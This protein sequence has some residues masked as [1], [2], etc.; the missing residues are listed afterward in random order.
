[1]CGGGTNDR[2]K[3]NGRTEIV[4]FRSR[5]PHFICDALK[6]AVSFLVLAWRKCRWHCG[7]WIGGGGGNCPCIGLIGGV[8]GSRSSSIAGVLG[9]GVFLFAATTPH[10]GWRIERR[11]FC[12]LQSLWGSV[13]VVLT[14]LSLSISVFARPGRVAKISTH[15]IW[16]LHCHS[17]SIFTLIYP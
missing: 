16:P 10:G 7:W 8:R 4:Y 3:G 12:G 13:W 14:V 6:K 9:G 11:L 17:F 15:Q 1:M 2:Q 5:R